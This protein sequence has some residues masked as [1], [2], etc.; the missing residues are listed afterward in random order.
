MMMPRHRLVLAAMLVVVASGCQ[1]DGTTAPRMIEPNL[2]A[3]SGGV[4]TNV[5]FPILFVAFVPCANGGAGE[6]I[7]LDGYLHSIFNVLVDG[8]GGFHLK[9]HDQPQGLSGTGQTTGDKYQGV[10]VTQTK[11]NVTAGQTY[12]FINNFSMI[13]QGPGNNYQVHQNYHLT[14][15]ANGDLTVVHDNLSITCG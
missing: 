11:Q 10:G 15:N 13:G 14:I 4:E 1:Q 9:I 6:T 2:A 5:R 12:T 8:N 3:N 7:L